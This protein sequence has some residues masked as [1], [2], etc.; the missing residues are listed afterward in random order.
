P[1]PY[2]LYQWISRYDAGYLFSEPTKG[3]AGH[4]SVTEANAALRYSAPLGSMIFSWTPE[5]NSRNWSG[6][7]GVPLPGAVFRGASDF[8]LAT[9]SP[10]PWNLQLGFTP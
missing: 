6:P 3:V 7:S 5:I 8:E 4:F 10:G 9:A 1:Q 2:R